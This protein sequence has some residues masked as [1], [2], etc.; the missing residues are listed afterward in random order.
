MCNVVF[1]IQRVMQA[2]PDQLEP[3]VEKAG[4][5]HPETLVLRDSLEILVHQ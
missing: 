3:Q 2:H 4:L 1:I 5:G